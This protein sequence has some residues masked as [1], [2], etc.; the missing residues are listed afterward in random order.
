[1]RFLAKFDRFREIRNH[2][3]TPPKNEAPSSRSF[4]KQTHPKW[5]ESERIIGK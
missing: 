1:M 5:E 2:G 3:S 4:S